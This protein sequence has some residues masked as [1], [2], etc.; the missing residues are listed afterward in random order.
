[1]PLGPIFYPLNLGLKLGPVPFG[2]PLLWL[3]VAVGAREFAQAVLPRASHGATAILAGVVALLTDLNLEPLAW[4]WRAWWLWYPGNLSAP[5]TPPLQ[6]Y[7]TWLIAAAA[8]AYA[9]RSPH[10]VPRL[11]R[12][13]FE[14]IAALAVLNAVCLLTHSVLVLRR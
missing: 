13:P 14:P 3:I 1:M 8:V 7:A 2:L 12:R 6:N 4:K 5:A 11:P 9:M 10:V